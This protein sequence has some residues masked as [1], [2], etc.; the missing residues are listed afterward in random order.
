MKDTL[1]NS[2]ADA[3]GLLDLPG[4]SRRGFPS[5]VDSVKNDRNISVGELISPTITLQV[6]S[7]MMG[8]TGQSSTCSPE[9][10]TKARVCGNNC[11]RHQVSLAQTIR[12]P[13]SFT[14]SS[15]ERSWKLR[16]RRWK[17]QQEAAEETAGSSG[18]TLHSHHAC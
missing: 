1:V 9:L 12:T 5:R 7:N 11:L 15:R 4:S 16:R 10:S 17:K 14:R 13:G 6:H 18:E 8:D 3:G 2:L